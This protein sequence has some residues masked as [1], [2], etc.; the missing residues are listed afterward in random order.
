M[1]STPF[2][3]LVRRCVQLSNHSVVPDAVAGAL[4]VETAEELPDEAFELPPSLEWL[5]EEVD[6]LLTNPQSVA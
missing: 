3:Y 4:G 5:P 2:G 1:L 6:G